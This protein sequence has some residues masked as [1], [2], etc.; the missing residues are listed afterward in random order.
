MAVAVIEVTGNMA[1]IGSVGLRV[2][3]PLRRPIG[4]QVCACAAEQLGAQF[5]AT[6]FALGEPLQG[7]ALER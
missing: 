6:V 5:G 4:C 3:A 2:A 1:R 7:S